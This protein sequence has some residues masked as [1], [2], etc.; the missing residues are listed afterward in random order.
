MHHPH[1]D[2]MRRWFS[3]FETGD[4]DAAQAVVTS[5]V[6]LHVTHPAELAGRYEG[7]EGFLAFYARKRAHSGAGFSWEVDDILVSDRHAGAVFTL[8][9]GRPGRPPWKQVAI[10]RI[11]DGR[12]AE[13]RLVEEP[14]DA[15]G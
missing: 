9:D 15:S 13:I 10:Y 6:V 4:M 7:F 1:L 3:A 5:D 14:G 8:T 11:E 2:V 12:I